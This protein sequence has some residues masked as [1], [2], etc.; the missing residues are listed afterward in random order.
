MDDIRC[1]VAIVERGRAD[2]IIARTKKVGAKGATV[3]Y[4]RGTGETE[5][6]RFLNI[7]I[8]SSKEI[9]II[10]AREDRYKAIYDTIIEVG[11]LKEPGTG[12]IFTVPISNL[13]GLYHRKEFEG[14]DKDNR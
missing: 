8:E 11:R 4:G 5:V 13:V 10:L 12:I 14:N 6:A 9:I 3:L 7:H 2:K 1:I